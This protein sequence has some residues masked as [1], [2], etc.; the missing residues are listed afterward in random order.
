[1]DGVRAPCFFAERSE[2][3][4]NDHADGQSSRM[5]AARAYPPKFGQRIS[6]L[7]DADLDVN[8][9]LRLAVAGTG[10]KRLVHLGGG[11]QAL[12]INGVADDQLHYYLHPRF[13]LF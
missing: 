3:T 8:R 2:V 1:M 12:E 5:L 6:V 13:S 9:L 4:I 11:I 7:P 10:R